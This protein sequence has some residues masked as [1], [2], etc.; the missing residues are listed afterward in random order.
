MPT[1]KNITLASST[2]W[3]SDT[4]DCAIAFPVINNPKVMSAIQ[5]TTT[6]FAAQK[7]KLDSLLTLNF[8][9]FAKVQILTV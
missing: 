9:S 4:N 3:V 5:A 1:T 6:P 8:Q 2:T 7:E